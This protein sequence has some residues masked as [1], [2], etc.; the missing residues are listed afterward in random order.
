MTA[1]IRAT[2]RYNAVSPLSRDGLWYPIFPAPRARPAQAPTN[3]AP[4]N[5]KQRALGI[6]CFCRR[7]GVPPPRGPGHSKSTTGSP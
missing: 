6:G 4:T 1:R 2:V 5:S 7:R 3:Q